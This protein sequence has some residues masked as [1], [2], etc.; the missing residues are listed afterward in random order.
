MG[1]G[2][3]DGEGRRP[4]S[5]ARG[6]AAVGRLD[7]VHGA[8]GIH[9]WDFGGRVGGSS[10]A[11]LGAGDGH[12]WGEGRQASGGPGSIRVRTPITLKQPGGGSFSK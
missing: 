5:E 1:D 3:T 9:G 10:A 2:G 11:G 6:Q 7:F 8:V 4:A 12:D